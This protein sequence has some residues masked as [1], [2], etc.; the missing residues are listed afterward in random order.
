MTTIF[1]FP[2][3]LTIEVDGDEVDVS[4]TL[5]ISDSAKLTAFRGG[6]LIYVDVARLLDEVQ[7]QREVARRSRA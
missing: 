6:T 4:E 3:K 2:A 1:G 5:T 7:V